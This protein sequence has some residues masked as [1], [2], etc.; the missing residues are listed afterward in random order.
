MPLSF[1]RNGAFVVCPEDVYD[2]KLKVV[3]ETLRTD[4]IKLFDTLN[5]KVNEFSP[6]VNNIVQF[7]EQNSSKRS[8][9]FDSDLL[10]VSSIVQKN[11]N[12]ALSL[13]DYAKKARGMC[14]RDF[15]DKNFYDLVIGYCQKR[16]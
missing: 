8:E 10:I 5:S 15:E 7:I 2:F 9:W 16:Q 6:N 3:P 13:L 14:S 1:R 11:Y 4:I 12:K